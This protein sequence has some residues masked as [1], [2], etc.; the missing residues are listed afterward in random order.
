MVS[1][2]SFADILLLIFLGALY[3]A[4]GCST[5]LTSAL[6]YGWLFLIASSPI[7]RAS[8]ISNLLTPPTLVNLEAAS[9]FV[10]RITPVYFLSCNVLELWL[11]LIAVVVG[12]SYS[13]TAADT[14][15]LS[16]LTQGAL[17]LLISSKG[18]F[19]QYHEPL[20]R[21]FKLHPNPSLPSSSF[22]VTN[23]TQ[24]QDI[25]CL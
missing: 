18:W 6:T 20:G 19:P 4:F 8:C 23:C 2:S 15:F 3:F 11:A 25:F 12:P 5:Y 7:S 21:I 13:F 24:Q 14:N 22:L 1:L 9:I 16:P 17:L 10:V